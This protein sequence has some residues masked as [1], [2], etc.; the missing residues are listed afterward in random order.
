MEVKVY[1][2]DGFNA[3]T[4]TCQTSYL[5]LDS[6]SRELIQSG[7]CRLKASKQSLPL[8]SIKR[9]VQALAYLREIKKAMIY[10]DSSFALNALEGSA[11]NKENKRLAADIKRRIK[12]LP[13]DVQ[14]RHCCSDEIRIPNEYASAAETLPG[15]RMVPADFDLLRQ[16]SFICD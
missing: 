8:L 11:A 13:L 10:T 2:G 12:A 14:I 9:A 7:K 3:F 1:V 15:I 6:V 5:I 4:E 16:L